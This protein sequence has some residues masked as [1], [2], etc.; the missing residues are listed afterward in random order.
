MNSTTTARA[1]NKI[2]K[3]RR[4][5][6]QRQSKDTLSLFPKLQPFFAFTLY[7]KEPATVSF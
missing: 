4:A 5:G 3:Q 2:E 7:D 1:Q 6:D